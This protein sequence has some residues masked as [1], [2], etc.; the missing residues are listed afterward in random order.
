[1]QM[2]EDDGINGIYGNTSRFKHVL[3]RRVSFSRP[4][5]EHFFQP[6]RVIAKCVLCQALY[7]YIYIYIW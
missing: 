6:F 2:T 7:S 1:M 5:I 4:D 3:W